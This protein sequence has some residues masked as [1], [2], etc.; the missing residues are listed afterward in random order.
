MSETM[1][2]ICAHNESVA[3]D[4]QLD[5]FSDATECLSEFVGILRAL[6]YAD[7]SIKLALT[8]VARDLG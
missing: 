2:K 6:G 4:A 5:E 1:I 7:A 3:I 8:E